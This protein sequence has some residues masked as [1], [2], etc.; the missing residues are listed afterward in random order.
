MAILT[1]LGFHQH[2]LYVGD[3]S[4]FEDIVV[5]I[6]VVPAALRD[7]RRECMKN[8]FGALCAPLQNQSFTALRYRCEKDGVVDLP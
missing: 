3:V 7:V 1:K 8:R 5:V 6:C 4:S 2:S